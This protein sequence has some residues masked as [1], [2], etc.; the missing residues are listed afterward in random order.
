MRAAFLPLTTAQEEILIREQLGDALRGTPA[1]TI[2]MLGELVGEI[3]T[4]R[5]TMAIQRTVHA[6]ETLHVEVTPGATPV[7]RV[8]PAEERQALTV[9]VIDLRDDRHAE[10]TARAEIRADQA[11]PSGTATAPEFRHVLFL[12]PN[13]RVW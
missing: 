4:R 13:R 8:I 6:A 7:Q 2:S 5:L 3:D 12:L 1:H 11:A 10:K 9:D